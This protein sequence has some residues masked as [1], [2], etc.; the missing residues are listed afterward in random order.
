MTCPLPTLSCPPTP[1]PHF[2]SPSVLLP[3]AKRHGRLSCIESPS[4]PCPV[5][6]SPL[7]LFLLLPRYGAS[8]LGGATSAQGGRRSVA[9]PV[10]SGCPSPMT[11]NAQSE[12][13]NGRQAWLPPSPI[14]SSPPSIT[15]HDST[16][17]ATRSLRGAFGDTTNLNGQI[18]PYP[19]APITFDEKMYAGR[20]LSAGGAWAILAQ[21]EH[22]RGA[23]A[24]GACTGRGRTRKGV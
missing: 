11:R 13:A 5:H 15:S 8:D 20:D 6:P 21:G 19:P 4:L 17:G 18:A 7:L 10:S 24:S 23:Q 14:P 16:R 2:P 3:A 9:E 22:G 12:V 1:A